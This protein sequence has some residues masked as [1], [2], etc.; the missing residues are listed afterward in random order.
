MTGDRLL[1]SA[2]GAWTAVHAHKLE[3]VVESIEREAAGVSAVA[4]DM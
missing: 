2:G 1:L 4:L 3:P